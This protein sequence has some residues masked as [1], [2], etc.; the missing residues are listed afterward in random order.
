LTFYREIAKCVYFRGESREK[1]KR[2]IKEI[3]KEYLIGKEVNGG[4]R[5]EPPKSNK[6][7]I[8]YIIFL[9]F[10]IFCDMILCVEL[11]VCAFQT[12]CLEPHIQNHNSSA[13]KS[14]I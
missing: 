2:K 14:L 5:S 12:D 7:K 9:Y 4:E 1:R 8:I 6:I 3:K 11:H 10:S 13:Y